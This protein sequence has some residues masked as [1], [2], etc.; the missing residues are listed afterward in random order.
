M[1]APGGP[2]EEVALTSSGHGPAPVDRR[3]PPVAEMAVISIM[4]MMAGGILMASRLPQ[5]PNLAGPGALVAFGG[6]LTVVDLLVLSRV[7]PFA[8]RTFWLVMRWALV[9]YVVITGLL[10]YVFAIN[11]TAGGTLGVLIATLIVFAVDVPV[12]LAFTVARFAQ[13]PEPRSVD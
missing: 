8:W 4:C 6:A 3:L 7:K 13:L 10:L 11:H 2:A 9:A 5:P 12:I 1:S